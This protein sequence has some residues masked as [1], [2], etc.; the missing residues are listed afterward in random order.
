MEIQEATEKDLDFCVTLSH[1]PEF[2]SLHNASDAEAKAYL[3]AFLEEGIL[4][5]AED[6]SQIIGFVAAEYNLSNFV[7]LDGIVVKEELRNKT[8]LFGRPIV[9]QKNN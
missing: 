2:T 7:W 3:R 8:P 1:I 9:Q 4:L 6:Q 5:V